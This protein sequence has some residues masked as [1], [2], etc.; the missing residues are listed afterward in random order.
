MPLNSSEDFKF[1][2]STNYSFGEQ[3]KIQMSVSE[4]QDQI[5]STQSTKSKSNVF[6]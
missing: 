2:T 3:G 6:Y 1:V 4:L 5:Q